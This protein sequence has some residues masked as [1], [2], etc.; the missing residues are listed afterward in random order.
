[1]HRSLVPPPY[2]GSCDKIIDDEYAWL[3][4]LGKNAYA[5]LYQTWTSTQQDLP[6]GFELYVI[7]FHV[8][9][10]N[11]D[12]L[13]RQSKILQVPIV[14]LS[15]GRWYD[16][17]IKGV[18]FYTYH[19]WHRQIDRLLEWYPDPNLNQKKV[20]K[21]ASAI[22][23]RVGLNKAIITAALLENLIDDDRVIAFGDWID[24]DL[25]SYKPSGWTKIDHAVRY[26]R[27]NCQGKKIELDIPLSQKLNSL[28]TYYQDIASDY[29]ISAYQDCALNFTNESFT[30]SL[31]HNSQ[32]RYIHP[33]PMLTEKTLKCIV[34]GTAFIP[35][36]QFE[37]YHVLE[38]LGLKF[39]YG[40]DTSWDRDPGNL[41]RLT[42]VIELI[43]NLQDMDASTIYSLTQQ[44]T[45][46]NQSMI[47]G[48]FQ[49][50][51]RTINDFTK[52][53][54]LADFTG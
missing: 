24:S 52:Q 48:D 4:D 38:S 12:W 8:E 51:C 5:A 31:M 9:A 7:S 11:L 10:I 21:K 15:D 27:Q 34:S 33:G 35:T 50:N 54:L 28:D 47:F 36:G 1:M 49:K 44:S 39:D 45:Q 2:Q 41:S 42:S 43:E 6:Q 32:G 26:F 23:Y 30:Y 16:L 20:T 17:S 40:F 13:Q 46:H 53:A 29:R 14:V 37:T 19:Y 18:K 22:C 25:E 3:A